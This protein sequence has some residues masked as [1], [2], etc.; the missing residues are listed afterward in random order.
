MEDIMKILNSFSVFLANKNKALNTIKQYNATLKNYVEWTNK[1]NLNI[2]KVKEIDIDRYLDECMQNGDKANTRNNKLFA[3]K[4]FYKYLVRNNIIRKN[5]TLY[6]E[7][8]EVSQPNTPEYLDEDGVLKLIEHLG[9]RNYKRN[10]AIVMFGAILGLRRCEI[11]GLNVHDVVNGKLRVVGKGNK[12]RWVTVSDKVMG[13]LH[14]YLRIR[15]ESECNALFLSERKERLK[16]ESINAFLYDVQKRAG[17]KTGVHIL[18][19]TAATM[20]YK[21][22]QDIYAVQ[23]LLGHK[24]IKTTEIYTHIT[25]ERN[26]EVVELNPLNNII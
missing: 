22:V 11:A 10:L 15:P 1:N 4:A 9:A 20:T 21:A 14:D 23:K 19:H 26:K 13:L 7:A 3:I 24:N 16:P 17:L 12:E 25:N 5:P 2:Y 6:L 18:R 8:L